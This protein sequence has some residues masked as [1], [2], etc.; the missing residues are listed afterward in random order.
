VVCVVYINLP[1]SFNDL[2]ASFNDLPASF[3]DLPASFNDLPASFNDLPASYSYLN[4][5]L[6]LGNSSDVKCRDIGHELR[7]CEL[8]VAEMFGLQYRFH[9][10]LE[11]ISSRFALVISPCQRMRRTE[12][13]LFLTS[14]CNSPNTTELPSIDDGRL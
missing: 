10:V 9:S 3:N 8:A 1:T 13:R 6:P 12:I 11:L 14:V 7:V 5:L 4:L 2:P